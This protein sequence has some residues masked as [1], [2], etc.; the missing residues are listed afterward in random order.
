MFVATE[1]LDNCIDQFTLNCA[2]PYCLNVVD[3]TIGG[4][5]HIESHL[6]GSVAECMALVANPFGS[7]KYPEFSDISSGILNE[8]AIK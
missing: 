6:S 5:T 7:G 4:T 2:G 8:F 3:R 1:V